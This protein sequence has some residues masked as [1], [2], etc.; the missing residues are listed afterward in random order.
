MSEAPFT[1][2]IGARLDDPDAVDPQ[3]RHLIHDDQQ[4]VRRILDFPVSGHVL[5]VGCSDGA[6]TR[7][8]AK[9][10]NVQT[11]GCDVRVVAEPRDFTFIQW[12]I[13]EPYPMLAQAFDVA[14]ACE[15]FEHLTADEA[16]E[17]L[18]NLCTWLKP[19]GDLIVTVPNRDCADH[20]TAGCRDRWRWPD[21][22]QAYT[23]H[24]LRALLQPWFQHLQE[25]PLY[26]GEDWKESIFLIVRAKGRK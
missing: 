23:P 24:R 26:D 6:V 16:A 18:R 17:A 2:H 19:G 3:Y 7:R 13:R 21:H 11:F 20:Y 8:I 22:R 15:V 5:D 4:R 10:W 9:R 1:D 14:F 25:I 12:D